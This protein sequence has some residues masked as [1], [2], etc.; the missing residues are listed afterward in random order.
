M[1]WPL[2]APINKEAACLGQARNLVK[3]G[4]EVTVWNRTAERCELAR[5]AGAAVAASVQEAV[6][7]SDIC[8][9]T[10]STPDAALAVGSEVAASI[11]PGANPPVALTCAALNVTCTERR[12]LLCDL[13][14]LAAWT[15]EISPY[16]HGHPRHL[17]FVAVACSQRLSLHV[18]M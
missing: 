11:Q 13:A 3:A 5:E 4:Y 7:A 15:A 18:Y 6:A 17:A 12:Q 14:A 8:F 1:L 10:L 2:E 9:A 16:T